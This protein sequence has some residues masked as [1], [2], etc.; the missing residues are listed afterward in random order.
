MSKG[1]RGLRMRLRLWSRGGLHGE[2][3][4]DVEFVAWFAA[5]GMWLFDGVGGPVV[6]VDKESRMLGS[7]VVLLVAVLGI[8]GLAW[9]LRVAVA[10]ARG[11]AHAIDFFLEGFVF[12]LPL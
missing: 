9:A 10:V 5:L 2:V 4:V 7:F 6:C 1:K 8:F 3:H 11:F 12:V